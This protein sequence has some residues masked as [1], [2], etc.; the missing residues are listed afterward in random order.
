[1]GAP[2]S[3]VICTR[4]RVESLKRCIDA[5]FAVEA[6]YEWEIVIVDNASTDGTSVF[7]SQLPKR[8]G[9]ANVVTT[10]QAKRGLAAAR[11]AGWRAS[12]GAIVA[13]TDDDC[14]VVKDYLDAMLAEFDRDSKLGFLGGRLLLYDESDLKLTILEREEE[15]YIQP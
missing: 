15:L 10:F 13:F 9:N 12:H 5:L 8:H 1:M 3:V 4:N 11:N 14:Y 7:L 6:A 2:I